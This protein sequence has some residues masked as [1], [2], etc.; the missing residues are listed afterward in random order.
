LLKAAQAIDPHKGGDLLATSKIGNS[1]LYE[2]A[3]SDQLGSPR[4]WTDDS[5]PLIAGGRHD[6]YPLWDILTSKRQSGY[7]L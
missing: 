2:Y 6:Y 1:G 3:T 5:G 4:A 7:Y